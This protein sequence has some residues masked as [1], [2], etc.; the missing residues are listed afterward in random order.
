M[1]SWANIGSLFDP[2]RSLARLVTCTY[3]T[4]DGTAISGID[5]EEV[6]GTLEFPDQEARGTSCT[7]MGGT[8]A[9]WCLKL[10]RLK[11]SSL[12]PSSQRAHI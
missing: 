6:S 12:S 8:M 10:C 1:T 4:E 7:G 11:L 5:Y 9:V 2:Q 3:R